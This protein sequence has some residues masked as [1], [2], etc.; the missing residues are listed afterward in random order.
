MSTV[1]A[2]TKEERKVLD[3]IAD[4]LK[5]IGLNP[6]D[7]LSAPYLFEI[8]LSLQKGHNCELLYWSEILK[9]TEE[10][11]KR[12]GDSFDNIVIERTCDGV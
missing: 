9:M 10:A 5:A 12:K 6:L 7:T 1:R 4:K 2:Y 11:F 8:V 3:D